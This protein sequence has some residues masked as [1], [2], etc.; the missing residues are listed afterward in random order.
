MNIY[1]YRERERRG[2]EKATQRDKYILIRKICCLRI[3]MTILK[4]AEYNTG[5][6]T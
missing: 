1:M 3:F 2:G 4:E 5:G 6:T